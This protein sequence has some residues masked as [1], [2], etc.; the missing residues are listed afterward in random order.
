MPD[1]FEFGG[2]CAECCA[3][4]LHLPTLLSRSRAHRAET[5]PSAPC[6]A[7]SPKAWPVFDLRGGLT[8]LAAKQRRAVGADDWGALMR[9]PLADLYHQQHPDV[10]V[11]DADWLGGDDVILVNG[12]WLPSA[13]AFTLPGASCVGM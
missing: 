11:N 12:R 8:T 3:Q 1:R 4:F 10:A 9:A 13:D 2:P 5:S 6:I 7:L